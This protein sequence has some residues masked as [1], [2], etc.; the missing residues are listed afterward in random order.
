MMAV[1]GEMDDGCAALLSLQGG[2]DS[3]ESSPLDSDVGHVVGAV[4]ERPAVHEVVRLTEGLKDK[5]E[6]SVVNTRAK[7]ARGDARFGSIISVHRGFIS[8]PHR[9]HA[10]KRR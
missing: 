9:R 5:H 6:R 7:V 8:T 4:G 10:Q 1:S 2:D 3:T